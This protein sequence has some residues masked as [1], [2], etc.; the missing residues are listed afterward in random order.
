MASNCCHRWDVRETEGTACRNLRQDRSSRAVG[1][2]VAAQ[3]AAFRLQQPSPPA[4][5]NCRPW[6]FGGPPCISRDA[7]EVSPPTQMLV[8]PKTLRLHAGRGSVVGRLRPP[9]LTLRAWMVWAPLTRS[10]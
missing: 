6:F 3:E 7:M 4:Q 2:A 5:K 1:R 9:A 10:R 8:R